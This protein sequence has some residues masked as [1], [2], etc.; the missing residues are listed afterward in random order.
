MGLFK[1]YQWASGTKA[2]FAQTFGDNEYL[3]KPADNFWR[4]LENSALWLILIFLIL[5]IFCSVSYYTWYNN[6]PG[7][8]Y[9]PLHWVGWLI[10]CCISAFLISIGVEFLLLKTNLDNAG[11]VISKVSLC[12]ALYA[13]GVYFLISLVWCNC[14]TTNACK[15]LKFK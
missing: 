12:N 13:S 8:H 1:I 14:F 9:K 11:I 3:R 2:E 10:V 7:R 15:F 5:G 6:L 4:S